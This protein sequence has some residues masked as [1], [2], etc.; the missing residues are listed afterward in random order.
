MKKGDSKKLNIVDAIAKIVSFIA[1]G[2]VAASLII[3]LIDPTHLS[4]ITG[5]SAG[6][7]I[8]AGGA[9]T[10]KL[11]SDAKSGKLPKISKVPL[12]EIFGAK[13]PEKQMTTTSLVNDIVKSVSKPSS[14]ESG[15][16]M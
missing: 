13:E 10:A 12:S 15:R 3:G 11:V 7:A 4:L 6:G 5:L 14:K 9:L 8:A 2:A 1:G 16:Q